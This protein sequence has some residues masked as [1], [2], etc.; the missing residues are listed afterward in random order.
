MVD[1]TTQGEEP[2]IAIRD[3]GFNVAAA[4]PHKTLAT[5][6]I[7]ILTERVYGHMVVVMPTT[8]TKR[9]IMRTKKGYLIAKDDIT[10]RS[11][12]LASR[13][14]SVGGAQPDRVGSS[15]VRRR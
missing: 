8:I 11:P 6:T 7:G 3:V 5:T 4:Y 9:H 1:S 13:W 15:S 12:A 14:C 10:G 2:F